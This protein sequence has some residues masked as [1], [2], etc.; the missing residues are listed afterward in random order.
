MYRYLIYLLLFIGAI[1]PA[2]TKLSAQSGFPSYDSTTVSAAMRGTTRDI[3]W[4]TDYHRNGVVSSAQLF[5]IKL[6]TLYQAIKGGL[7][8][9]G[10][11][12]NENPIDSI[13]ILQDSILVAYSNG[14]VIDQDTIRVTGTIPTLGGDVTGTLG[15][16]V[17]G[18]DSHTHAAGTITTNIVSSVDGVTA[19]GSNIDFVASGNIG[20]VPSDGSDNITFTVTNQVLSRYLNGLK[21]TKPGEA[22]NYVSL[23]DSSS[24]NELQVLSKV[25]AGTLK[26]TNGLSAS[27]F[28]NLADSS[29]TGE[30]QRVDTL[31]LTGSTL[32]ISLLNDG[33][34]QKTV[35]LTGVASSNNQT[36]SKVSAGTY[37]LTN[38]GAASTFINVADSSNTSEIQTLS[39]YLL[40]L[41]LTN[42]ASASTFI[43]LPDSNSANEGIL[44]LSAGTSTTS[45]IRSNTPTSPDITVEVLGASTISESGNKFTITTTEVD[46]STVNEGVISVGGSTDSTAYISSN[47]S[48][49]GIVV[50][51]EGAGINI[52]RTEDTIYITNSNADISYKKYVCLLSQS[53][54]SDPTEIVLENTLDGNPVWSRSSTG[55][56]LLTLSGAFTEDLTT[57]QCNFGATSNT[58]KIIEGFRSTANIVRINSYD[59]AGAAVD[60]VATQ[61]YIEVRVYDAP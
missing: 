54:T 11:I 60:L 3:G 8:A 57:V 16:S 27:T 5:G 61:V 59:A 52:T 58:A 26:L 32:G 30:L 4:R 36:L 47:T 46:G 21:L 50:F 33:V 1:I 40:G 19:D 7:V 17:V 20:I 42:G 55:I 6:R 29:S 43:S 12:A 51:E 35:D 34:A 22:S 38:I 48:G 49:S 23:P 15:A 24:V 25:S 2:G 37:K 41:K 56:Y 45:L 44:S 13:Q 28:I 18:N 9:D 10:T 14:T 31:V 53:G 39:R